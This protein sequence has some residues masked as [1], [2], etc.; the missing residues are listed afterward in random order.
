[1]DVSVTSQPI[2]AAVTG[3]TVSASVTSSS[4]TVS[5]GGG[6][7][8]VG[9]AGP[10]GSV[11]ATGPAN[12]LTI[13]TVTGGS[14]A[15]ATITGTAPSQVLNLVLPKGDAG[16]AGAAG[17]QGPAGATGATGP[18]GPA[19][20]AASATTSASDLTSGTLADARLSSAIATYAAMATAANQGSSAVD[21]F[22]R[23]E[24]GVLAVP[25]VSGTLWITFFTPTITTTVS[26]I[27]MATGNTTA[28]S[29]LTLARM[30]LYTFDGST[31]ALVARC[32]SDTSLFAATATSYQRSFSTVGSFPSSYE[33]V[34]GTR[35][36]VAVLCTGTT[37]PN[38]AARAVGI[39]VSAL[40]PR[41]SGS[42]NSQTDL[43]TSATISS[44]QQ[45]QPF[46]RLS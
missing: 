18:Q 16:A 4:S 5:A 11:G 38:I 14:S 20:S 46:A 22:P 43:P 9:A 25:V 23:G 8:P 32:A 30:G 24:A 12:T 26:S 44:S 42:L 3:S 10:T 31:A 33:L 36:G 6:V 35:Y 19:G 29:G 13:G 1:M 2:T 28:A 21:V 45:T 37:M 7:G 17:V 39:G 34:A 27:T 15:A 40:S 41:M